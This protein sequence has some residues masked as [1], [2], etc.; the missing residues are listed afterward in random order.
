MACV[1][2]PTNAKRKNDAPFIRH[3]TSF[4][5]VGGG[6]SSVNPTS[7]LG[8]SVVGASQQG[9][10]QR[11]PQYGCPTKMDRTERLLAALNWGET[12]QGT[13]ALLT[14]ETYPPDLKEGRMIPGKPERAIKPAV[15]LACIP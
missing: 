7:S 4:T 13:A 3:T 15:S 6:G 5:C 8:S 12:K 14:A 1:T 2:P 9:I 10:G 11:L